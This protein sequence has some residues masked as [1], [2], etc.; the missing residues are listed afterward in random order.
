MNIETSYEEIK[1]DLSLDG[2]KLSYDEN[3]PKI[4]EE[5]ISIFS[6]WLKNELA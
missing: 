3:A 6:I 1:K 2:K 4:P 5:D